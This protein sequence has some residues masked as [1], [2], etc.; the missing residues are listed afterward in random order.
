[1]L[2][3]LLLRWDAKL[4]S[5]I[6]IVNTCMHFK[7]PSEVISL[8]IEILD[9]L[10]PLCKTVITSFVILKSKYCTSWITPMS[11]CNV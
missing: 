9:I 5:Q 6:V 8:I 3:I 11:Y 2:S 1:M 7:N 10:K 4:S